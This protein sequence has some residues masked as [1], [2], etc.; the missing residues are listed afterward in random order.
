MSQTSVSQ[1]RFRIQGGSP[2]SKVHELENGRS[3]F[4]GGGDSCGI[5]LRGSGIAE[6]HCLVDVDDEGVSVQDWA[7]DSGTLVNGTRVED[8]TRLKPGDSVQIG[9][10]EAILEGEAKPSVEH[11]ED[12]T[13]A[14][15]TGF[16]RDGKL[17][18]RAH[19]SRR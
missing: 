9:S 19:C 3:V 2:L 6:I 16:D 15:A 18:T 17:G 11:N 7:S 1:F 13:G 4:M 14:A 8:K 5:Q 12:P 10:V